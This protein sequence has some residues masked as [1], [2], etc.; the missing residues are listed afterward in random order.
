MAEVVGLVASIIALTKLSAKVS[1]LTYAYI[2][3]VKRAP[4]ELKRL[5]NELK[6][7]TAVLN[8]LQ[9]HTQEYSESIALQLLGDPLQQCLEE[10]TKL[11]SGLEPE[12]RWL[13]KTLSRLK[14][15]FGLR[16]T[17]EYISQVERFKTLFIL[18]LNADQL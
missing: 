8:S 11:Q 4:E 18:A 9:A 1:S 12:T 2:T 17:L 7:L 5:S 15:P 10:L 13:R 16:E 6:S 3:G 14:R